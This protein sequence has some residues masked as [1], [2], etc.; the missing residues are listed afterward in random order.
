RTA[1]MEAARCGSEKSFDLLLEKGADPEAK[2]DLGRRPLMYA[3]M[4]GRD[5][6]TMV[7]KLL[8]KGVNREKTDGDGRMAVIFAAERAHTESAIALLDK[9]ADFSEWGSFPIGLAVMKGAIRSS[10]TRLA[11]HLLKKKLPLNWDQHIVRRL[12]KRV[13]TSGI[14]RLMAR[15]DLLDARRA[16]LLVA[17]KENNLIMVKFLLANG[18]DI[19]QLDEKGYSALSLATDREVI[20]VLKRERNRVIGRIKSSRKEPVFQGRVLGD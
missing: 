3:C 2:D 7:K 12:L 20:S 17:A 15:H 8:E 18:A 11:E 14:Y 5:H 1:L 10:D 19:L 4:G 13:S 9:Y 6:V 16:P